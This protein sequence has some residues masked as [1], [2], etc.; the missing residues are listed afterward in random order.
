MSQIS[1]IEPSFYFM[2]VIFWN[3]LLNE[4]LDLNQNSQTLFAAYVC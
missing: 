3:V 4:N 1:Y 2:T